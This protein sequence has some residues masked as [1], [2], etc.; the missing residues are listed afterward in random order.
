MEAFGSWLPRTETSISRAIMQRSTRIFIA[1]SEAR[2]KAGASSA[3]ECTLVMPAEEPS[4]AALTETGCW[5][6][7]SIELWIFCGVPFPSLRGGAVQPVALVADA[8][9]HGFV[10]VGVETPNYGCGR[11]EG[12]FVFA[13]TAAEEDT[14]AESFFVVRGHE[15][16]SFRRE[17]QQS[18]VISFQL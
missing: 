8:D 12:D 4:V 1:N 2:F 16:I 10:F 18:K 13:G 9:G 5:D 15:S 6:C 14:N 7:A 17:V 11:G 3:R